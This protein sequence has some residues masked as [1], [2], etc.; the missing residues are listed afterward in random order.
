MKSA[1][2]CIV[3]SFLTQYHTHAMPL[4][5]EIIPDSIYMSRHYHGNRCWW[6]QNSGNML[7]INNYY[8]STQ[9]NNYS[10]NDLVIFC[11]QHRS[12]Q[13]TISIYDNTI[14]VFYCLS[15]IRTYLFPNTQ[16]VLRGHRKYVASVCP[17]VCQSDCFFPDCCSATNDPRLLDL[18]Q[19]YDHMM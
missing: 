12:E 19:L 2:F 5:L 15:N 17:L 7:G 6:L 4:S 3:D 16:K 8:I 18:M 10:D 1:P 13:R 9:S 14:P 11:V